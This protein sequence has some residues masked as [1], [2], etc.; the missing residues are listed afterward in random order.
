MWLALRMARMGTVRTHVA[1]FEIVEVL[2]VG[3]VAEESTKA[4][5]PM[6]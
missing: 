4:T 1:S 6:I 2:V 3:I 5:T